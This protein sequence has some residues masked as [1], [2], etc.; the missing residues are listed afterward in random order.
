[1]PHCDKHNRTNECL[2]ER[3]S[4]AGLGGGWRTKTRRKHQGPSRTE[5]QKR[6][7]K[8]I[9]SKIFSFKNIPKPFLDPEE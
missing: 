4:I 1:M 9:K 3:R 7:K 5:V 2:T 8:T 6:G